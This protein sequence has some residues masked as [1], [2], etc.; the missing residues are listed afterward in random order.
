MCFD[1]HFVLVRHLRFSLRTPVLLF[2]DILIFFCLLWIKRCASK[3]EN[4]DHRGKCDTRRTYHRFWVKSA[5][6]IKNDLKRELKEEAEN[7]IPT[8]KRR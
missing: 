7:S 3:V 1:L 2:G 6:Q 8:M 4:V 5:P